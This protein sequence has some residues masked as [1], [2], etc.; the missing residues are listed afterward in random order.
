MHKDLEARW[1]A[2][3]MHKEVRTNRLSKLQHIYKSNEYRIYWAF[4]SNFFS[5]DLYSAVFSALFVRTRIV[6]RPTS[7][8]VAVVLNSGAVSA[9]VQVEM[10]VAAEVVMN[11]SRHLFGGLRDG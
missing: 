6:R 5:F 3:G 8:F 9:L 4:P 10:K 7:C 11:S 2:S 1:C